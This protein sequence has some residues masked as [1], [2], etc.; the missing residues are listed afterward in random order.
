ML[1]VCR[2]ADPGASFPARAGRALELLTAQPGCLGGDLGRSVD[3][4]GAWVLTVRF[5]TVD[6]YRRA[7][8]PFDVRAEVVPLLSEAV[9]DVSTYETLG[10]ATEGRLVTFPSLRA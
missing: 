7:L 5:A 2:F 9:P 1:L 10:R 6:A 8:S 4:P 3:E